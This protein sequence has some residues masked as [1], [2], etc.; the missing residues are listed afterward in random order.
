MS[1]YEFIKRVYIAEIVRYFILKYFLNIYFLKKLLILFF[2]F[3]H[4]DILRYTQVKSDQGLLALILITFFTGEL[5]L[6]LS[7]NA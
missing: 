7:Q 2:R 3:M 5:K 4:V 6:I 1:D